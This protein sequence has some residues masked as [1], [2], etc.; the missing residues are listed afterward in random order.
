MFKLFIFDDK[1]IIML[2]PSW[3]PLMCAIHFR[4]AVSDSQLDGSCRL[5]LPPCNSG[6]KG[7]NSG[8]E[9]QWIRLVAVS[10]HYHAINK[11]M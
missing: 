4:K 7:V 11:P 2:S 10:K 9:V 1:S 5:L 3:S 8:K 6:F